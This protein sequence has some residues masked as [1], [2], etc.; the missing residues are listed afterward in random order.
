MEALPQ[1]CALPVY[2]LPFTL[3]P[4]GKFPKLCSDHQISLTTLKPTEKPTNELDSKKTDKQTPHPI[5]QSAVF[6]HST[7]N[8]DTC[9]YSPT[10]QITHIC[11]ISECN[12]L[13][14]DTQSWL[15]KHWDTAKFGGHRLSG[16]A[17]LGQD[18]FGIA[19]DK[20]SVF[21]LDSG[22]EIYSCVDC[23]TQTFDYDSSHL[24]LSIC[25]ITETT[26]H[27]IQ[28]LTF[29]GSL[30]LS[31]SSQFTCASSILS[32]RNLP[33]RLFGTSENSIYVWSHVGEM[34]CELN[35]PGSDILLCRSVRTR[36]SHVLISVSSGS[37]LYTL[38]LSHKL[39][40]QKLV[41]EVETQG[42]VFVCG[43]YVVFSQG[44]VIF[45]YNLV[46]ELLAAKFF[47]PQMELVDVCPDYPVFL[48]KNGNYLM[49]CSLDFINE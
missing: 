20:S 16:V 3:R 26:Q 28:V 7:V 40:E 38:T 45:V 17:L 32:L 39:D 6:L 41:S 34:L 9:P 11:V 33:D 10:Y 15:H 27:L 42:N 25:K 4:P 47:I 49:I 29:A 35:L 2:T 24:F 1:L 46:S 36:N 30:N 14:I 18:M 23:K 31:L 8:S 13:V 21:L 43:F 44:D 37:S 48:I 22:K 5:V 19:E 12:V